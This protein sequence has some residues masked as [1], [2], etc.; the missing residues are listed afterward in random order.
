MTVITLT[1]ITGFGRHGVLDFERELGQPFVVDVECL[2]IRPS[3]E[4]DLATTLDYGGLTS[5]V[6]AQIE[7]EPH[8]LIETLAERI[9]DNCLAHDLVQEVTVKVHKPRA[10]LPAV[11]D[12]AVTITRGRG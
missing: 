8:R 10:P 12:V 3:R 7:G 11:A 5:E 6:L 2:I 9:A 4:D 1:G